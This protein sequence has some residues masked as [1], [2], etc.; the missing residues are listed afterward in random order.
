MS[1]YNY[2]CSFGLLAISQQYFS[3][4]TETSQTDKH[5]TVVERAA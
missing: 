3:L 2:T 4:R 5:M 1:S